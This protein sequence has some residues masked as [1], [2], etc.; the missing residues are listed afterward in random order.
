MVFIEKVN[1][2]FLFFH[3]REL[4]AKNKIK[5]NIPFVMLI[6]VTFEGNKK[7][8]FPRE[9]ILLVKEIISFEHYMMCK[10]RDK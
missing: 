1:F 4:T 6:L 2:L 5:V 3:L 8:I 9:I 10:N 7:G